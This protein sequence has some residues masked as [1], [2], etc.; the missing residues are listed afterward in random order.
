MVIIIHGLTH[1]LAIVNQL[2]PALTVDRWPIWQDTL[3]RELRRQKGLQ[4]REEM[5]QKRQRQLEARIHALLHV[6]KFCLHLV[7]F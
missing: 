5:L 3:S 6:W 2:S 7:D 4:R 1:G